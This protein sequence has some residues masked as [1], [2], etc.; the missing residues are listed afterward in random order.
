MSLVNKRRQEEL[1]MK[2]YRHLDN[3]VSENKKA[4]KYEGAPIDHDLQKRFAI[5]GHYYAQF[6]GGADEVSSDDMGV[7]GGPYL[8][9]LQ[10]D[11]MRGEGEGYK[12]YRRALLGGAKQW[13]KNN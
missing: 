9:K 4:H 8:A 3:L 12:N 6:P 1:A 5:A 7:T 2:K 11:V 13:K 10:D